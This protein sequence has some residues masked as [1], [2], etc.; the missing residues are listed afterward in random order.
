MMCVPVNVEDVRFK[1][2]LEERCHWICNINLSDVHSLAF[3]GLCT[4]YFATHHRSHMRK[5]QFYFWQIWRNKNTL[6]TNKL[7]HSLKETPLKESFLAKIVESALNIHLMKRNLPPVSSLINWIL[8][9]TIS[10]FMRHLIDIV[11]AEKKQFF[12]TTKN[13]SDIKCF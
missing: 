9:A 8:F 12:I 4:W 2:L 6:T 11:R 13:C 7:V 3:D 10:I 5:F 1:F